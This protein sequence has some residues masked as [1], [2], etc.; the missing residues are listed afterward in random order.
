[1]NRKGF[2][3]IELIV[4]IAI[5]A[6]LVGLVL[7]R[8]LNSASDARDARR[9]SELG[10]VSQAIQMFKIN[11]GDLVSTNDDYYAVA[12]YSEC[13]YG[14]APP[15]GEPRYPFD[16]TP[17]GKYPRDFLQGGQYPLDPKRDTP[18][19]INV[20][21]NGENYILRAYDDYEPTGQY[22]HCIDVEF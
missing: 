15:C 5:I 13:G 19:I 3:L 9:K 1:M 8:I 20:A 10:Q 21:A 6:I 2:T 18:Y 7:M 22:G 11:G 16:A 12:E 17:D 4:V 14:L